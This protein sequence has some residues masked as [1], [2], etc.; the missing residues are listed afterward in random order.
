MKS[1]L[2]QHRLLNIFTITVGVI[3]SIMN[4]IVA[5]IIGKIIDSIIAG[6]QNKFG[7]FTLIIFIAIVMY[8]LFSTLYSYLGG[9]LSKKTLNSMKIKVYKNLLNMP[10]H[11]YQMHDMS[12]YYNMLTSDINE[13][14]NNYIVNLYSTYVSF[15]TFLISLTALFSINILMALIF[16]G[17]TIIII[18]V[19]NLITKL[20][21][22]TRVEFS[23]TNENYMKELENILSGFESIKVLNIKT[24]I[25]NKII[26]KEFD[27][28]SKRLKK[29]AVDGGVYSSISGISFLIQLL[30]V[31]I[32]G[33]FVI[34]GRITTGSLIMAIQ[35]L[36]S[37]FSPINDVSN[38]RNLM[39]ATKSLRDK[40]DN[41]I[42]LN[43]ETGVNISEGDIELK[44]ISLKLGDKKIFSDFNYKFT[45][46]N[47]YIVIGKSGSGKSTL[48]KL[49]SGF[50]D[51]Y[52]GEILYN[53][54]E[55][56]TINS[57]T[58]PNI[59]RYIGTNNYIIN[60]S[61]KENIRMYREYSDEEVEKVAK[62]VGFNDDLL[63][64]VDLGHS[65]KF[66]S[67]GEYQ[68]LAIA[69]VMLE[70]PYCVILDEPT[71]NLDT[72]NTDIVRDIIKKLDVPIKI[73]ISHD[74]T[75]EYLK[76]FDNIIKLS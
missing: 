16:I 8:I 61:L 68:R 34:K 7:L 73:V 46:N 29:E 69:R 63:N 1:I 53:N 9:L 67:A 60:D 51:G 62:L 31:L 45:K 19:P 18:I 17:L 41:Y 10:I 65:G 23:N 44:N 38:K 64:K 30:C 59:V 72:Y 2:K 47:S 27:L 48:A 22:K 75:D 32:G 21:E 55:L 36:N 39:K 71:A 6:E 42:Y 37:V 28:E 4:I 26:N 5:F 11:R 25:L 24:K 52:D 13:I 14:N 66:I 54:Q 12:F 70:N 40:I 43:D 76:S 20:Q 50:Y 3:T 35:I 33:Y 74:Y 58:I 57:N 49:I 56:K 15:I